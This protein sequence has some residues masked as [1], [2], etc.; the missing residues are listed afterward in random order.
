VADVRDEV[1]A[2]ALDAVDLGHV[3]HDHRRAQRAPLA[4]GDGLQHEH[5]SRRPEQLQFALRRVPGTGVVE[6]LGDRAGRDRVGVARLAVSLGRSVA[7]DLAAVGVD[8]DHPV[9]EVGECSDETIPL[10][11]RRVGF[12]PN[13]LEL[14]VERRA[15][16]LLAP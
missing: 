12:G 4:Q 15:A 5:C 8:D 9:A 3:V 16:T 2:H 11:D 14:C 10:R 7:E 6:E 1:S 13:L